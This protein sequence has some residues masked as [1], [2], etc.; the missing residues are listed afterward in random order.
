MTREFR[1]A[2]RLLRE[3]IKKIMKAAVDVRVERIKEASSV[4]GEIG[5]FEDDDLLIV[6][7]VTK[8][9]EFLREEI[10]DSSGTEPKGL[11]R[12]TL[13]HGSE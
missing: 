5:V 1:E 7:P 12:K 6:T 9:T 2:G 4:E 11:W 8:Q 3:A 10:G 13:R